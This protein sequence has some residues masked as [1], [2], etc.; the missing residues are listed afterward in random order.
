VSGL[1]VTTPPGGGLLVSVRGNQNPLYVIDGIPLLSESNSALSTSFNLQGEGV[2]PGQSLSSISDI[3]PNDIESIEILKDASAAAIYG[4]RAA[5]GVVLITTKRGKQGKTETNFNFYTGFQKVSRP[6]EFL[7]SAE[8]VELIEEARANDFKVYEADPGAFGPDFDPSVLRD[9]LDNFDLSGGV[10][11]NW[12]DAVTRT[13]PSAIT[14][15]RCAA[16]TTK[17]VFLPARAIST[18]RVS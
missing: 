9:P 16:A 13:A 4:A 11:T 3:N 10:N 2:G 8:F 18:N 1:N 7:S 17:R 5:N 12:L 14:N 6:I 15:F